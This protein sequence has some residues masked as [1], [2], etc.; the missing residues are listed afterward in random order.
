MSGW[1]PRKKRMIRSTTPMEW[2]GATTLD[3]GAAACGSGAASRGSRSGAGWAGFTLVT[4]GV[5]GMFRWALVSA[6][7]GSLRGVPRW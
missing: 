4:A 3:T 1:L 7:V 5:A 6:W 2:V